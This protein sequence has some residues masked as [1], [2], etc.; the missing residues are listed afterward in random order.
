MKSV[1]NWELITSKIYRITN[2]NIKHHQL[3]CDYLVT[4]EDHRFWSH[5]GVDLISIIRA[6]W[7]TKICNNREGGSTIAMQLIRTV[8]EDYSPT[9]RRKIKEIYYAI[10]ISSFMKKKDLLNAY[11]AIAYFGWNMHGIEQ[12]CK[13]LGYNI[14]MLSKYEAASL[15]ARLKYPE[16]KY[17]SKSKYEKIITRT[18]YI[19]K[20]HEELESKNING[21]VHCSKRIEKNYLHLS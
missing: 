11:L 17:F 13:K 15:V 6:I 20:R 5:S 4:A 12:A 21:E 7:K 1:S 14:E 10:R 19:I 18:F 16:P 2:K 8:T 9:L 3:C